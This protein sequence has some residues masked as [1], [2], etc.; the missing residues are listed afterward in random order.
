M[1]IPSSILCA[2]RVGG[3]AAILASGCKPVHEDVSA[4]VS[5]RVRPH[6]VEARTPAPRAEPMPLPEPPE[7]A[8]AAPARAGV[9]DP[10]A[11]ADTQLRVKEAPPKKILAVPAPP[12]PTHMV[13]MGC[14]MG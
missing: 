4:D 11:R 12:P 13:V 10:D 5:A 9:S 6:D 2:V 14:G 3:V 8:R 1:K 7:A